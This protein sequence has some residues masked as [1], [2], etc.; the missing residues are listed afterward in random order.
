MT[1]ELRMT[2]QLRMTS[3]KAHSLY[4]PPNNNL[5]ELVAQLLKSIPRITFFINLTSSPTTYI[6]IFLHKLVAQLLNQFLHYILVAQVSGTTS[7]FLDYTNLQNPIVVYFYTSQW[8][9]FSIPRI[10]KP[11]LPTSIPFNNYIL[12]TSILFH[13]SV[14]QLFNLNLQNRS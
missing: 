1:I 5:H 13:K 2:N 6:S 4:Q 9:N 11:S 8:H 14:A 10:P 3:P 12:N 7:Y